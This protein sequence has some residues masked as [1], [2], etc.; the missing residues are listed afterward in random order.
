[1]A[2]EP[3]PS[4][5]AGR[6]GP[7]LLAASMVVWGAWFIYRSS[8]VAEGRRVFCLFEDAMISMTYARNL[9]EGHG[10]NWARAG[11]PVEGFTHP[12]WTAL[13]IPANA[14]GIDPRLRSLPVQLLSLGVLV[15]NVLLVR[16][17]MLRHFSTGR[18]R[19]WAPAA[20]LTASY[21]P[22]NYWALMGMETGL[23]A[24]LI[25]AM[26]LVALDLAGD[27]LTADQPETAGAGGA[28]PSTLAAGGAEPSTAA[29]HRELWLLAAAAYLLRMDMLLAVAVVQ[30]FVALGGGLRRGRRAGWWQGAALFGAVA[31]GYG[32]FRW[33]YF[34]DLLPNTYYLKLY[35]I[36]LSVRLGRGLEMLQGSLADHLL[37][38]GGLTVGLGVLALAALG[39]GRARSGE[40]GRG[41]LSRRLALPVALFVSGCAYSVYVGGDAWDA[42]LHVRSN[43]FVAYLMPQLFVVFNALL[44]LFLDRLAAREAAGGGQRGPAPPA[45]GREGRRALPAALTALAAG[46]GGRRALAAAATAAALLSAD[47]LWLARWESENWRALAVADPPFEVVVEAGLYSKLRKLQQALGPAGVVSTSSAGIPAFFSDYRMV[48][49][50]GYNERHIAR[51]PPAYPLRPDNYVP[52]HVKWDYFYIIEHYD[53]DALLQ[54]WGGSGIRWSWLRAR[55]YRRFRDGD[56]WLRPPPPG[57]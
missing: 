22:L 27:G 5:R 25:T 34:H 30:A 49:V 9:L 33:F 39:G 36:P 2:P 51:L 35:R 43:R 12:L 6:A 8:F 10:L 7:W 16:R 23:Q 21:Y 14:A 55:G 20:L 47:G 48:D 37:L 19:S 53:P 54:P 4:P 40:G 32:V 52:G 50:L 42:D 44:N 11:E 18:T 3:H 29:R 1:M 38:V 45:A 15:A 56:F 31:G 57:A 17:L 24:L 46:R 26:V 13:M 41:L 28:A